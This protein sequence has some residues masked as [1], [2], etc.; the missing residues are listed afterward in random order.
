[1]YAETFAPAVLLP[2]ALPPKKRKIPASLV[3]ETIDGVPFYYAGYQRVLNK[4]QT[5]E[6]IM[7]DSGLQ[8]FIKSF[9]MTLLAQQL[10][11]KRYRIFMGEIGSHLDHRS[12]LALDLAVFDKSLLSAKKINLQYIDVAPKIVVEVDVN[13]QLEDPSASVFEDFVLNKVRKLHA[14][15][16]EKIIWVFSKSR[17]VIVARPDNKWDVLDWN[18]DIELLEG[19]TFNIARHLEEEGIMLPNA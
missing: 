11:L 1:M 15:G 3:K 16:T 17:T 6:S 5:L 7:A 14:F 4:T 8:G 2:K 19:I 10:D 13:V 12:N 18:T 9:L